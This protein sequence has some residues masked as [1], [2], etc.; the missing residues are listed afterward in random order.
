MGNRRIEIWCVQASN[1]IKSMDGLILKLTN[2]NI[3]LFKNCIMVSK[4]ASF[5]PAA[6]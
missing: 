3:W 1:H 5:G 6:S 2:K 4:P